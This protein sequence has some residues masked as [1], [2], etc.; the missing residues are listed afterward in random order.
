MQNNLSLAERRALR[1]QQQHQQQQGVTGPKVTAQ[2]SELAGN[3]AN[4]RVSLPKVTELADSIQESGIGQALTI[5]PVATFQAA[6]PEHRDAVAKAAFVVI[7]GN[8]RLAAAQ[9]L[10]LEEVPV[11]VNTTATT[12]TEILVLSLAEN[13]Q[14]EDLAPL[15]ELETIEQLSELLGTFAAVAKALGKSEGWVSQRRRLR[16]LTP[17]A[18][19]ALR[20]GEITIE[21]ARELGKTKDVDKQQA[22][23]SSIRESKAKKA[24]EK[25][26]KARRRTPVVPRQAEAHDGGADAAEARRAACQGALTG[27]SADDTAVILAALQADAEPA[28]A[29]TL[30]EEWL[31]LVNGTTEGGAFAAASAAMPRQAA[32]ALALAR[33][34]LAHQAGGQG[35]AGYVGWLVAH[36]AYEPTESERNTLTAQAFTA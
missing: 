33:C 4:P 5:V 14:R 19:E 21:Q 15:E 28:A 8:R 22:S 13:I 27:D 24:E 29:R 12:R 20:A 34:E 26:P 25:K 9:E 1:Q 30:A 10:K 11:L 35:A 32:L 31:T 7:N 18:T 2:L 17:E 36:A 3:P 23:L 6:F 16:N